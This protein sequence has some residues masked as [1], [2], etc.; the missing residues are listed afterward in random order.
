MA[1][2]NIAFPENMR[3]FSHGLNAQEPFLVYH[4]IMQGEEKQFIGDIHFDPQ[5]FIIVSGEVDF[6]LDDYM[7]KGR[8]GDIF[9]SNF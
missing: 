7:F 8:S 4:G 3:R 5:L 1:R 2:K 6:L 9:I